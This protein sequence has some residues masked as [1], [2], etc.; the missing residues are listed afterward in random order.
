MF[1]IDQTYFLVLVFD[2]PQNTNNIGPA[3]NT[4]KNRLICGQ[5]FHWAAKNY[6]WHLERSTF[7]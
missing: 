6:P 1:K 4:F 2:V 3:E 7:F 5:F